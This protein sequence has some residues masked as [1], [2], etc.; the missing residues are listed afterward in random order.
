VLGRL[1]KIYALRYKCDGTAWGAGDAQQ[2]L[3]DTKDFHYLFFKIMEHWMGAV[4]ASVIYGKCFRVQ[5]GGGI[6]RV[7]NVRAGRVIF[8]TYHESEGAG[9]S[10]FLSGPVPLTDFLRE[11]EENIQCPKWMF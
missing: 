3:A 10:A 2:I 5:A 1:P 6:R 11:I 4:A 7:V 9:T 8:V